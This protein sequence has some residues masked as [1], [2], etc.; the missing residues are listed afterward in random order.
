M[1]RK[2]S[3]GKLEAWRSLVLRQWPALTPED[4]LEAG[5]ERADLA[6]VV[7]RRCGVGVG[8]AKRQV[9]DL[10][11]T[12]SAGEGRPSGGKRARRAEERTRSQGSGSGLAA[13]EIEWHD[14]DSTELVVDKRA[15]GWTRG[16]GGDAA[17]ESHGNLGGGSGTNET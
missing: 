8:E 3:A 6:R 15:V 1:Q 16:F 5:E 9:R 10:L 7:A 11:R 4:L 13:E 12:A 17:A 2:R 14:G